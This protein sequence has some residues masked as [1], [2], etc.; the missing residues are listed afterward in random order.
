MR[1]IAAST[2]TAA[3]GLTKNTQ[4]QPGPSVSR[5]PSSTPAAEASPPT[6]PHTPR[7]V[8]RSLPSLKVVVRIESAAGSIIAAP[9][10]WARRAAIIGPEACARPP[11]NDETAMMM[12][13]A[14]S[15][16]RRPRRSAALPPSS[17]NPP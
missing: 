8:W 12:V 13:P 17:M 2:S 3:T 10:P 16:R 5:P 1:K 9:V 6:P 7:A 11:I 14:T 15:T 4:R